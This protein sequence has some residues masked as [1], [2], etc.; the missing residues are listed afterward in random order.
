MISAKLSMGID[1]V[2]S[3]YL[4]ASDIQGVYKVALHSLLWMKLHHMNCSFEMWVGVTLLKL[5]HVKCS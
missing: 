4:L 3:I 1:N 2:G 5:E